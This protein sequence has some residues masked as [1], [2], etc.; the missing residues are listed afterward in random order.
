METTRAIETK[1]ETWSGLDNLRPAVRRFLSS[2]CKDENE[3]EDIVQETLIRAARYR[4]GLT[5]A[6]RLRPWVLSIAANVFRDRLHRSRRLPAV[7]LDEELA[8]DLVEGELDPARRYD[9]TWIEIDGEDVERDRALL[10]LGES[11]HRLTEHD[12]EVLRSYYGGQGS[13]VETAKECGLQPSLAKVR[14]FRARRRLEARVRKHL[15]R[16]RTERL[17]PWA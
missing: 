5:R 11:F 9:G 1:W 15:A 4:H 13:C 10:L 3:V 17:V 16:L 7:E 12:R 8:E 2:R 14:L 6:D